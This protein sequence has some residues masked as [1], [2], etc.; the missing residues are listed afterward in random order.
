MPK[1]NVLSAE[2]PALRLLPR[3][4]GEILDFLAWAAKKS[5][6]LLLL[7]YK[8]AVSPLLPSLCKFH[9]TCSMYAAEAV[10]R[11]GIRKGLWL[12]AR[13]LLRCRPFA[14]G[15]FDPVPDA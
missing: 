14:P 6:V 8:G 5:I 11:H 7:F 2:R 12:A 9:P 4:S 10:E 13:R 15:G 1:S 3:S